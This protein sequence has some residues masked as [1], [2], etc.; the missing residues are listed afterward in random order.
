MITLV[1]KVI[2]LNEGK[3]EQQGKPAD[4]FFPQQKIKEGLPGRILRKRKI[5]NGYRLDVLVEEVAWHL[6]V[7]QDTYYRFSAGQLVWVTNELKVE[8]YL[9]PR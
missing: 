1:D 5:D 3:V 4:V 2:L 9:R 8:P 7:D 6:K